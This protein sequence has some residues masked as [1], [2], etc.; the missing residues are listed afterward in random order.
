MRTV[1]VGHPMI[2]NLEEKRIDEPRDPHLVGLFPGSRAREVRK[3]LPIMLE[4][5]RELHA[6]RPELRFEIAAASESLARHDPRELAPRVGSLGEVEV[7][8]RRGRA[9]DAAERGRRGRLRHRDP[10]GG[11]FSAAL[12]VLVYKVAALTYLAGRM[13]DSG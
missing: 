5:M 3:L 13:L 7:V 4:V 10:G 9:D 12:S 11:L 8:G 2:E 1:F 6:R